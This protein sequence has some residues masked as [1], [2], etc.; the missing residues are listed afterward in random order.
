MSQQRHRETISRAFHKVIDT[1]R[2]ST[3]PITP[4]ATP[5][6]KQ[7]TPTIAT[8]GSSQTASPATLLS[9]WVSH[10]RRSKAPTP[11]PSQRSSFD[12]VTCSYFLELPFI[13]LDLDIRHHRL[14][15]N[16]AE[17]EEGLSAPPPSNNNVAPR[18]NRGGISARKVNRKTKKGRREAREKREI[19]RPQRVACAKALIKAFSNN[20]P[21]DQII[22]EIDIQEDTVAVDLYVGDYKDL[23]REIEEDSELDSFFHS[24]LKYEYS[25]RKGTKQFAIRMP[26]PVHANLTGAIITAITQ[27]SF[28]VENGMSR[29]GTGEC[30]GGNMNCSHESTRLVAGMIQYV[31]DRTVRY[32]DKPESDTNVPDGSFELMDIEDSQHASVLIEVGWTQESSKLRQ[33]CQGYIT[34]SK[35]L[36]RTVVG[37]DL[38]ELYKCYRTVIGRVG[39]VT[40]GEEKSAGLRRINEMATETLKQGAT[41]KISVWHSE[42]DKVTRT[43]R[44]RTAFSNHIFRDKYGKPIGN[45]AL[46]LSL[47]AFISERIEDQDQFS[48]LH[49]PRC[50]ISAQFLCSRLDNGLK[51]IFTKVPGDEAPAATQNEPRRG[52]LSRLVPDKGEPPEPPSFFPKPFTLQQKSSEDNPTE[53]NP[54]ED[55]VNPQL[56]RSSRIRDGLRRMFLDRAQRKQ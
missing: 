46:G 51:L 4:P 31:S 1:A 6:L 50:A 56:R 49:N 25:K 28:S 45:V 17:S 13:G 2:P 7:S 39:K 3:D 15:A 44:A 21:L 47:Q 29:C 38:H 18:S 35:G 33:K 10:L 30:A 8:A 52:F 27:W 55:N 34:K 43:V 5:V 48:S 16:P 53:D 9:N 23:L 24:E 40:P 37:V 42:W 26:T 22:G 36:V 41:G 54:T 12:H 14:E 19:G 20:R 32:T 11:V